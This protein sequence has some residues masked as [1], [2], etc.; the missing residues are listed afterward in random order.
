VRV[1]CPVLFLTPYVCANASVPGFTVQDRRIFHHRPTEALKNTRVTFQNKND[2]EMF[3]C[4]H[5]NSSAAVHAIKNDS[6]NTSNI[7]MVSPG[8]PLSLV[9]VYKAASVLIPTSTHDAFFTK[10]G[11]AD[12]FVAT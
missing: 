12:S 9:F 6:W 1:G 10:R 2:D 3:H 7:K 11:H 8:A 4:R 5:V